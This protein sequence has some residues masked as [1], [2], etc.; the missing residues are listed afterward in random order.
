MPITPEQLAVP[1]DEHSHQKAFFQYLALKIV[2]R[3]PVAKLT[4]AIPNGAK[5]MGTGT[6]VGKIEGGKMKAEGLR[7]G[8]PDVMCP[9]PR[10]RAPMGLY[11][12][13]YME[14]KKPG[15]EDE[16][17]G[18]RSMEQV[19]WQRD[20]LQQGYAVATCYGWQAMAHTLSLYFLDGLHMPQGGDAFMALATD[21]PPW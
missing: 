8:V 18:G 5:L 13:L 6:Q 20:L 16:K 10:Q 21:A 1:G 11:H 4:H 3:W 15:R 9:V 12:G 19:Q 2:P 14:L 17:F 7:S